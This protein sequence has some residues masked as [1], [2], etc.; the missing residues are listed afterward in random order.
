LPIESLDQENKNIEVWSIL[1]LA[2]IILVK[3]F[4]TLFDW[5]INE[6]LLF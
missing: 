3:L 1:N 2:C 5:K 4:L 6:F